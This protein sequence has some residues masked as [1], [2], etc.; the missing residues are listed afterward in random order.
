MTK[1]MSL[2]PK[3]DRVKV[4]SKSLIMDNALRDIAIRFC[5]DLKKDIR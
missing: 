4:M 1:G 3:A 2:G 5:S